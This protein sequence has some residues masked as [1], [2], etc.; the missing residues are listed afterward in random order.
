MS[1]PTVDPKIIQRLLFVTSD[2]YAKHLVPGVGRIAALQPEKDALGAQDQIKVLRRQQELF[3]DSI[4]PSGMTARG[5]FADNY[6]DVPMDTIYA[7]THK[8]VVFIG[9]SPYYFNI[10]SVNYE[11]KK[12]FIQK[13]AIKNRSKDAFTLKS[14]YQVTLKVNFTQFDDLLEKSVTVYS[15]LNPQV[16]SKIS[17]LQL[18]YKFFDYPGS[19]FGKNLSDPNGL[20]L[21]QELNFNGYM[22]QYKSLFNDINS[23]L[24]TKNYHLTYYKHN[25]EMFKNEEPIYKLFEN[26]LTIEYIAYEADGVDK[27]VNAEA[28]KQFVPKVNGNLY[29]IFRDIGQDLSSE[30]W[31]APQLREIENALKNLEQVNKIIEEGAKQLNC[32]SDTPAGKQKEAIKE[33]VEKETKELS[34]WFI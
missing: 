17:L 34:G 24:I 9:D 18:L 16:T 33:R 5:L 8:M 4:I 32:A 12:F 28:N 30:A 1:T 27:P 26:E 21:I 29:R 19:Q 22:D 20:Y 25:F 14:N 31:L 23:T 13:V 10:D 3:S 7:I 11:N 6:S 2:L 15:A